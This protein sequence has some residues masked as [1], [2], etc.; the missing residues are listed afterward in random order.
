[1][2]TA[3]SNPVQN[4]DHL[5]LIGE[6]DPF[7][8]RLLQ[9]FAEK[10]GLK[11][12]PARTGEDVFDLVK[13][14]RPALVILDPELPGRVRGWEVVRA[15]RTGSQTE[16]IPVIVCAWSN[17]DVAIALTGPVSAYLQKPDLHYEDFLAAL[18]LLGVKNPLTK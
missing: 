12:E 16:N 11:V 9:L 6:S 14:N 10:S 15:L 13:Q 5:C 4:T 18:S 3:M 2:I 1:M 7:L 17:K 8:A